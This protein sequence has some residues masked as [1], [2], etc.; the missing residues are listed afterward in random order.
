VSIENPHFIESQVWL[1]SSTPKI[2]LLNQFN[3]HPKPNGRARH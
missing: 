3:A 1:R 2:S